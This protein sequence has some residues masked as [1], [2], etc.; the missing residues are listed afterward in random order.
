LKSAL[1]HCPPK[2]KALAR[3]N[4]L[5]G[6]LKT[7]RVYVTGTDIRT[8]YYGDCP[9]L[10]ADV[11]LA[12]LVAGRKAQES[13]CKELSN[14]L[15]G[16]VAAANTREQLLKLLPEFGKYLPAEH[17]TPRSV[18]VVTNIVTDFMKAGWPKDQKKG[19]AKQATA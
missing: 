2:V 8:A 18:P 11:L 10:K 1:T 14:Q 5:R 12:K 9:D 3:D 19:N 4:S 6:F 16:A 17:V 15:D 13:A 7:E